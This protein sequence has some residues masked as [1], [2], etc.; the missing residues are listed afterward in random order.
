M[1]LLKIFVFAVM[2]SGSLYNSIFINGK[3]L[4]AVCQTILN[5]SYKN[6]NSSVCLPDVSLLQAILDA[7]MWQDDSL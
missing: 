2:E 6:I 4:S 7:H 3:G 1:L 5:L